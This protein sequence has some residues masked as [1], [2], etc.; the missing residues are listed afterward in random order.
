MVEPSL[1]GSLTMG[2]RMAFPLCCLLDCGLLV[3]FV[4]LG[5]PSCFLIW[6]VS[7]SV[8]MKTLFYIV[9]EVRLDY[10]VAVLSTSQ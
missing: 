2:Q 8:L 4:S 1:S 10:R 6:F 9:V 7:S 3:Y 5:K